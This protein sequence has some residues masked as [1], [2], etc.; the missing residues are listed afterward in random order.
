M[1]PPLRS[2]AVNSA[3]FVTEDGAADSLRAALTIPTVSSSTAIR[4]ALR[5]VLFWRTD[6]K[7][8]LPPG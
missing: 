6:V 4:T 7:I 1:A 2:A 5:A 8:P 3:A